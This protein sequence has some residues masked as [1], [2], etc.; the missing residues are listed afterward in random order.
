M[1]KLPSNVRTAEHSNPSHIL[2]QDLRSLR[3]LI[4]PFDFGTDF[5]S[6]KAS[7]ASIKDYLLFFDILSQKTG[8][9][10]FNGFELVSKSL[11]SY[12]ALN[13]QFGTE[14]ISSIYL[15]LKALVKDYTHI[16]CIGPHS[17]N[18][19]AGLSDAHNSIIYYWL[20]D[21]F[22]PNQFLSE[23]PIYPFFSPFFH[24]YINTDFQSFICEI[25]LSLKSI[26]KKR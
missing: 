25:L 17:Y 7:L 18:L 10:I 5:N 11:D 1:K 3:I 20:P 15:E 24:V 6:Y 16:I 26:K 21:S 19:I 12:S 14:K 4:A 23:C 22:D 2:K 8:M 9:D 13:F